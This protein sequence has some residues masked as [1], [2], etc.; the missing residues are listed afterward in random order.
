[1]GTGI[2][3]EDHACSHG[4][5]ICVIHFAHNDEEQQCTDVAAEVQY[6]GVPSR[7]QEIEAGKEHQKHQ[8]RS[9]TSAHEPIIESD[10]N[11]EKHEKNNFFRGE[12]RLLLNTPQSF[13]TNV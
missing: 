1:M 10:E 13:L 6:F 2:R 9:C 11:D 3:T 4:E 5:A 7:P 12:Y 8:K